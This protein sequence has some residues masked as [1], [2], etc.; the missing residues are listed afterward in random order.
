MGERFLAFGILIAL[1]SAI[2][3]FTKLN[4]LGVLQSLHQAILV[5]MVLGTGL[6]LWGLL[7]LR[8]FQRDES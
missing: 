2:S 8:K 6:A 1:G 4:E 5:V 3:Y 7:L